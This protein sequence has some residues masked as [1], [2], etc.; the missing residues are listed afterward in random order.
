[1]LF[2]SFFIAMIW[3]AFTFD[4]HKTVG[5]AIAVK[6]EGVKTL[7]SIVG[8]NQKNILNII[9]I[10]AVIISKTLYVRLCQFFNQSVKKVGKNKYEV[11]YVL[12][13]ILYKFIVT[14]KRGPRNILQV[15]ND[16]DQDITEIFQQYSG[17]NE[18]FYNQ[19]FTPQF[20]ESESLHILKCTGE[21]INLTSSDVIVV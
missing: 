5:N 2:L 4:L 18:D 17:P 1:M 7:V 14:A 13:G 19:N 12:N 10:C 6:Y 8:K 15:I 16:K 21:E 11:S 3:V 9:W 20:F